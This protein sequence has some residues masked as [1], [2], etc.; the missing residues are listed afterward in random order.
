LTICDVFFKIIS[1]GISVCSRY[2]HFLDWNIFLKH[3]LML[4]S[5][6]ADIQMLPTVKKNETVEE[7]I[8]IDSKAKYFVM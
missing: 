5:T 8:I 4:Y 1:K 6:K 2:G 3:T 7:A